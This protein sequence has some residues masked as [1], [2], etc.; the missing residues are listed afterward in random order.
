M[1]LPPDI[2]KALDLAAGHLRDDEIADYIDIN[3]P[4]EQRRI[5]DV[6]LASCAACRDELAM[7]REAV[8][9]DIANP[10]RL[11]RLAATL[12]AAIRANARPVRFLQDK[13]DA[14]TK[15]AVETIAATVREWAGTLGNWVARPAAAGLALAVDEPRDTSVFAGAHT[16]LDTL[17]SGDIVKGELGWASGVLALTAIEDEQGGISAL[18][19]TIGVVEGVEAATPI[20][21]TIG[22]AGDRQVILT[23]TPKRPSAMQ[24]S[25]MLP[26]PLGDL[27][28][29]VSLGIPR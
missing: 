12:S 24:T 5:I 8:E 18:R 4:D 25:L 21:V 10:A 29:T 28:V 19:A 23:L 7:V 16:A 17:F 1:T 26:G 6:H 27:P 11:D 22:A 2:A 9:A 14:A 13:V 15:T 20:V 3:L